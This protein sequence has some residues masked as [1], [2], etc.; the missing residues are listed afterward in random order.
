MKKTLHLFGL[1]L[2]I[3]FMASCEKESLTDNTRLEKLAKNQRVI[4]KN[5]SHLINTYLYLCNLEE[6]EKMQWLD[7]INIENSFLNYP[8][9]Y[10]DSSLSDAP[11]AWQMLFNSNLEVQVGDTIAKYENGKVIAKS[12][13][14][15]PIIDEKTIAQI[16]ITHVP[17][18]NNVSVS[19]RAA[20]EGNWADSGDTEWMGTRYIPVELYSDCQHRYVHEFRTVVI[21]LTEDIIQQLYFDIKF[22]YKKNQGWRE[23]TGENRHIYL[24]DFKINVEGITGS[25]IKWNKTFS[26]NK[27]TELSVCWASLRKAGDFGNKWKIQCTGTIEHSVDGFPNTKRIDVW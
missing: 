10:K 25:G 7:S 4:F 13:K 18:S 3:L 19:S 14:G 20:I 9:E 16:T 22:H 15:Q 8:E 23:A 6:E 2:L 21:R 5:S 12:I 24:R 17:A 11:I 27:K 1:L 26:T